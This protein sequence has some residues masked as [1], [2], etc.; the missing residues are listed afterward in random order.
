MGVT[1][2]EATL[3]IKNV[4]HI[5]WGYCCQSGE[6][7]LARYHIMFV[8]LILIGALGNITNKSAEF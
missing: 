6:R 3:V 8:L 4:V 7:R 2:L 5:N 1:K